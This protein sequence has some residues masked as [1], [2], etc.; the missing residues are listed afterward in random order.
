M[1]LDSNLY[2]SVLCDEQPR[3]RSAP[4]AQRFA[5]LH[6]AASAVNAPKVSSL[7]S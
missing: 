6:L 1:L 7:A 2:L 5:L 3:S 4:D